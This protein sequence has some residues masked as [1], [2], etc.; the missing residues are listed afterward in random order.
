MVEASRRRLLLL[1]TFEYT[2][3]VV[4]MLSYGTAQTLRD[5]AIH[6]HTQRLTDPFS[7]CDQQADSNVFRDKQPVS[8]MVISAF[9][10]WWA[11]GSSIRTNASFP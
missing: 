4:H 9:G 1:I 10:G 3:S 5:M 6:T 7:D 2:F 8:W 11:N